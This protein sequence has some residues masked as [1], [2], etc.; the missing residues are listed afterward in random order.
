V[1]AAAT[2]SLGRLHYVG[3]VPVISLATKD[4][5]VEVRRTAMEALRQ[6]RD[7]SGQPALIAALEAD[8]DDEVRGLAARALGDV[9][10]A[11]GRR[12]LD[13]ALRREESDHVL[14]A[15]RLAIVEHE[16]RSR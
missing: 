11:E 3:A 8:A 10:Q 2:Q 6:I 1:R 5:D 7:I 16:L 9:A 13:A 14:R 12:A 15:I 4:V